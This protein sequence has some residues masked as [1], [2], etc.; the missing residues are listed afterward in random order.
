MMNIDITC[1]R[2]N[3][4][5]L[6]LFLIPAVIVSVMQCRKIVKKAGFFRLMKD[7]SAEMGRMRH[8]SV[9][10]TSRLVFRSLAWIMLVLACS[11]ISWGTYLEPVQK[12]GSSV[13]FVFDI[14]YSMNVADAAGG[15]TRLQA[16]SNYA[17]MLLPHIPSSSV[18]VVLAK[19]EGVTVVPLTED[20]AVIDS[21]LTAI[22]P[23]LM[24]ASGTSLG[25]G[26]RTAL[27][28][29]PETSGNANAIWVFT[30]GDE[31]DGQLEGALG[32]CLRKGVPVYII[33]F[34]SE[35]ESRILAGDGK[36]SVY[37]ALRSEKMKRICENVM[38]KNK[39][40]KGD[41]VQVRYVDATE[42]GSALTLLDYIEKT[43]G[44]SA[45]NDG[46]DFENN[47]VSYEVKP[48]QRYQLFLGLAVM[49]FAL[50]FIVTEIDPEKIA[51]AFRKTAAVSLV[52]ASFILT[53]CAENTVQNAGTILSS[54]W[55]WYQHKYNSAVAGF[56]QVAFDAASSG[57]EITEQYAAYDLAA[58]YLMQNENDAA[59]T[60]FSS[61]PDSAPSDIR[62]AS[63]YNRG[64]IAYKEGDYD[65][66]AE[67]FINALKIDGKKMNAKIN[68]EL[69][70]TKAEK[71]AR[72]RENMLTA[73]SESQ[74][75]DTMENS[76][77][78]RIKEN[79]RNQW[80]NSGQTETVSS[81]ADY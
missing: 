76:I 68:L 23:E 20:R 29:F 66:A 28:S 6:L 15:L 54:S 52:A 63:W 47:F 57:D 45:G 46:D 1:Q 49:F 59:E 71:D 69:S 48:V 77:F 42:A 35:S 53:S 27:K 51:S 38:T 80:K 73:V 41:T 74:E 81:A 72:V 5:Y 8:F 9:M 58:T 11:G 16:A 21:L 60:R 78:Q 22:S 70:T 65:R 4:L 24:S 30:D 36:T 34:G 75:S 55:C 37:T 3:A 18:S 67:C 10:M 14:S 61:I 44:T 31:T 26:V 79:D 39:R 25:K 17:S 13:C 64:I 40:T 7:S 2:P 56:L 62:Y 33:G 43:G 19:G 12:N 32:E 50:G